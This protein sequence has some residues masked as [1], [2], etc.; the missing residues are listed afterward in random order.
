MESIFKEEENDKSKFVMKDSYFKLK[1]CS[2]EYELWIGIEKQDHDT[3]F[4]NS[5]VILSPLSYFFA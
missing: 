3:S 2:S 4:E 5:D 1:H